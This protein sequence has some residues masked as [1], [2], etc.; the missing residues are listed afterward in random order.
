M[1]SSTMDSSGEQLLSYGDEVIE[2][3]W[4]L[5]RC[6]M[7]AFGTKRTFVCAAVMSAFGGILLQNSVALCTWAEF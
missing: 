6:I 1:K 7:S 2:I 4:N 5:L 3:G